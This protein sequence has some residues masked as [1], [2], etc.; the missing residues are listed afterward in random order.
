MKEKGI[1]VAG[2]ILVDEIN[3]IDTY[4]RAGELVKISSV[5]RSVGGC[6]PNVAIDLKRMNPD[7][8]VRAIGRV[9]RDDYGTFVKKVLT[10][11]GVDV[12]KVI[13]CENRTSFTQVMSVVGGQRTFFTYAGANAEFGV[14]DLCLEELDCDMLHLG[15][16][17]LMQKM[18]DGEGEKVLAKAKALG[19]KTSIDFVSEPSTRYQKILPCLQYTDNLIINETEAAGLVGGETKDLKTIAEVLKKYGVKERVIIH[20]AD[21]GICLSNDGFTIVGS[22]DLPKE[23]IKGTTGAGDAFCAG[24]LLK[25]KQNVSDREILEFAVSSATAAISEADAIGGMCEEEKILEICKNFK[26]KKLC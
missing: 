23:F 18:D 3:E 12:E 13:E 8:C 26:R 14:E 10:E 1:A 16:F 15:Y 4:P 25:I 20:D 6:V 9:G 11:N 24:A 7:L 2:V 22:Y 5:K 19:M 17:L 21:K